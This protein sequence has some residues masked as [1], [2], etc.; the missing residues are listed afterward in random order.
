MNSLALLVLGSWDRI[1]AIYSGVNIT[2]HWLTRL[3]SCLLLY[4]LEYARRLGRRRNTDPSQLSFVLVRLRAS[5]TSRA[6]LSNQ[7][8][9]NI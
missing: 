3:V 9:Y 5:K 8:Q 2:L 6:S 4:V 1:P 7:R